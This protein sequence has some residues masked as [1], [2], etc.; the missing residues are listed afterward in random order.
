M[1]LEVM[2]NSKTKEKEIIG[3][4]IGWEEIKILFADDKIINLENI[5]VL[6]D[7]EHLR[8]KRVEQN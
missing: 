2:V 4:R 1:I 8:T 3:I 5:N 7:S 6:T